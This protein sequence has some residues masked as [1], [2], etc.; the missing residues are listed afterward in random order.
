MWIDPLGLK[1]TWPGTNW[2]GPGGSGPTT[3]CVD[4]ACKAHDKCYEDKCGAKWYH[5]LF[6][7]NPNRQLCM[8]E[9]DRILY[10]EY[11]KCK[12]DECKK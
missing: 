12:D 3:S 9:C 7:L 11:K 8:R 6:G 2:C 4:K 5:N 1:L 10:V